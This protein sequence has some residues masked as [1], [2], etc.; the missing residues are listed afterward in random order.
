MVTDNSIAA[1]RALRVLVA[2]DNRDAADSLAILLRM[3]GYD[4]RVCY[5]GASALQ[6][7]RDYRSDC[8]LLDI[9]MPLM[10]G[11]TVARRLRQQPNLERVKLVALTVCSDEADARRIRESG[12]DY[13]LIKPAQAETLKKLLRLID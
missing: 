2:D 8:L 4:H 7:A 11:Y 6:T 5:D 9:R 12:F 10:N 1:P 3:W 13:Y